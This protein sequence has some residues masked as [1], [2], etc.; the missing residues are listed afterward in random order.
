MFSDLSTKGVL[1]YTVAFL[2]GSIGMAIVPLSEIDFPPKIWILVNILLVVLSG[3][4]IGELLIR[5]KKYYNE[6]KQIREGT[7]QH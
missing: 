1:W 2:I 4:H 5:Y 7:S 3:L 6:H